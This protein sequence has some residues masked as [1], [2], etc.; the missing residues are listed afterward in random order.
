MVSD[1]NDLIVFARV[2]SAGGFSAAARELGQRTSSVSRRVARLESELGT[3]LLVRST[4]SSH[5]TDAGRAVYERSVRILHEAEA[6]EREVAAITDSPRGRVKMTAPSEMGPGLMPILATYL[7]ENEDV[8]VELDC[9]Q[10]YVDLVA[11]GYDLAL[12]AGS[13]KDS[14]LLARRLSRSCV[15]FVASP[16]YLEGHGAPATIEDLSRHFGIAF[17]TSTADPVWSLRRQGLR[18]P[19]RARFSSNSMG[20]AIGAAR[21]GL[22]LARIPLDLVRPSLDAGAL[23]H[24]LPDLDDPGG[25]MWLVRPPVSTARPAVSAL[26]EHLVARSD[27]LMTP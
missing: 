3:T 9:T 25:E 27:E 8:Q 26:V 21:E 17:G 24:V 16:G 4:R 5:L 18:I 2:V 19:Y 7:Q 23:V 12:R 13:L 1:L 20:A 6:A 14:S 10:R 22:G 11:E 15:G